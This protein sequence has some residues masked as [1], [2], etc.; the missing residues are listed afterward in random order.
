MVQTHPDCKDGNLI[1]NVALKQSD[2]L[3]ALPRLTELVSQSGGTMLL[4]NN[5]NDYFADPSSKV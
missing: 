2:A 1:A 5:S 3:G 4:F